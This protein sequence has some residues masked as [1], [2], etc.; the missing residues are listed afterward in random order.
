MESILAWHWSDGLK[1][2]YDARPIVVG[3]TLTYDGKEPI[4][5][6]NRGLHA[7]LKILDALGYAPGNTISRVRLSG[8][9]IKGDDKLVATKRT[10]LWA[11]DAKYVLISWAADCAERAL[12]R[13]RGEGRE[14]DRTCFEAIEAARVFVRYPNA[15]NCRAARAAGRAASTAGY[16][17]E[18]AGYAASAAGDVDY[19]AGDAEFLRGWRVQYAAYAAEAAYVACAAGSAEAEKERKWQSAH[20]R[21]LIAAGRAAGP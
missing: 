12:L 9:I 4:K 17:A 20:L 10:C 19:A 5:L 11:F 3:E 13:E 21:N 2:Q 1:C 6:C 18:A 14:P 15:E 16:A 8:Q 7:S